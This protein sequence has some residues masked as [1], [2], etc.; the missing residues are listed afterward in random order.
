VI[1]DQDLTAKPADSHG[2]LG[3]APIISPARRAPHL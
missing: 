3:R 2:A 1:T